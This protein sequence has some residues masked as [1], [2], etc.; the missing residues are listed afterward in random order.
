MTPGSQPGPP[1][2]RLAEIRVK[3]QEDGFISKWI[4]DGEARAKMRVR[5]EYLAKIPRSE[6]DKKHFRAIKGIPGAFELKWKAD[7]K[8]FRASGYYHHS[9]DYFVMV[10]GYTH[11]GKTYDQPGWLNT[12]KKNIMDAING[13]YEIVEFEP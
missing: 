5:A 11:K 1:Y 4:G 9:E 7:G 12:T 2:L 8:Q 6:W 3:G 10:L 13:N